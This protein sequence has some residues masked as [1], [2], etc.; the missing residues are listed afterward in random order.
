LEGLQESGYFMVVQTGKEQV[1]RMLIIDLA[2]FAFEQACN[3][4][5]VAHLKLQH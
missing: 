5:C 1:V 4:V 3:S 2:L